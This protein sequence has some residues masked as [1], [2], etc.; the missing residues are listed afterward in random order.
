MPAKKNF[1][2][3]ILVRIVSSENPSGTLQ[4]EG[5]TIRNVLYKL[6]FYI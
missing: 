4:S 3:F 1:D 5:Y 2:I 6:R